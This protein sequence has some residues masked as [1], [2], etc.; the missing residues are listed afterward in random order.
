AAEAAEAGEAVEG[1]EAAEAAEGD[2]SSLSAD[3]PPASLAYV[4]YTSGSTGAPKGVEVSHRAVVRLVRE[5]TY[6]SFGP[7]EVYIQLAPMSF[8]LAT[9]ELWGPLL[10][11]GRL[12]LLPPGPYTLADVYAAGARHGVTTL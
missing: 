3:V 5:A 10:H 4:L 8:D 12:A 2:T 6:A 1:N 7:G 11:G 9:L